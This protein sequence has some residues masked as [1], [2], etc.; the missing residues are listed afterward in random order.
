MIHISKNKPR[1][2][3]FPFQAP[4]RA[5]TLIPVCHS[6]L[7]R[8][9]VGYSYLRE[10]PLPRLSS[11]T[12]KVN[13][14]RPCYESHYYSMVVWI[15]K[16][17][18]REHRPTMHTAF[19]Q[20]LWQI[21]YKHKKNKKSLNYKTKIT[22][23]KHMFFRENVLEPVSISE[24]KRTQINNHNFGKV[25][26]QTPDSFDSFAYTRGDHKLVRS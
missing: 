4:E 5:Y 20:R 23:L 8:T 3:P 26:P 21:T 14:G 6:F 11:M 10:T 16:K 19:Q 18:C 9:G 24:S 25:F 15:I 1:L 17:Q 22:Q 12:H 7:T 2:F 13:K